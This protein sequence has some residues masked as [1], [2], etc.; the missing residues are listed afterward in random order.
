[1]IDLAYLAIHM[2]KL[3]RGIENPTV[4]VEEYSKENTLFSLLTEEYEKCD[5]SVS[6]K[7]N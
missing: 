1:M 4:M 3:L 6:L 5:F 2:R 7:K